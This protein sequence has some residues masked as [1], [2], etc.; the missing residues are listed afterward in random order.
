[1]DINE[2]IKTSKGTRATNPQNLSEL[3]ER[4]E[5]YV[6]DEPTR[7][8]GL[9]LAAGVVLTVMPVGWLVGA[10]LRLALGLLRPALLLLGGVKLYEEISKR[11]S[12]K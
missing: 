3:R 8:V 12:T 7:A 1:M 2:T 10:V 4:T 5:T 9:A 6:R 11:Y